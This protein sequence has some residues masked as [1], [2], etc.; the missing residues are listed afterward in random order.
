LRTSC[1]P[2]RVR[3]DLAHELLAEDVRLARRDLDQQHFG[4]PSLGEAA[5]EFDDSV[6]VVGAVDGGDDLHGES[7]ARGPPDYSVTPYY[8]DS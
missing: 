1:W 5:G 3:D 7:V 4:L 6:G 2:Y 8:G